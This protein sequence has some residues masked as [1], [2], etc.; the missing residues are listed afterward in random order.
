MRVEFYP[1]EPRNDETLDTH[2]TERAKNT[3]RYR[4]VYPRAL[5]VNLVRAFVPTVDAVWNQVK[6]HGAYRLQNP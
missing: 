6:S 3:R 5:V 1:E 2:G 4:A